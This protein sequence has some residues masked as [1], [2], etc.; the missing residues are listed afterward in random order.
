MIN[1]D[2]LFYKS[3]SPFTDMNGIG[4]NVNDVSDITQIKTINNI[5]P[6]TNPTL[7]LSDDQYAQVAKMVQDTAKQQPVENPSV[8]EAP[9]QNAILS[10]LEGLFKSKPESATSAVPDVNI[11]AVIG[12]NSGKAS[13]AIQGSIHPGL[14]GGGVAL[15]GGGLLIAYLEAQK[16]KRKRRK[17]QERMR[18]M[19]SNIANIQ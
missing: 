13:D 6:N 11:N 17:E 15:A 7:T 19:N 18:N 10:W 14:I 2:L 16:E 9:E 1:K 5:N 3:A 12:K 4:S 8:Q